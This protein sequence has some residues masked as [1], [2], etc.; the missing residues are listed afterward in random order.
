MTGAVGGEDSPANAEAEHR[1]GFRP[2]AGKRVLDLSR[3]LAGPW[4][5]QILAD[6]GADVIKVERPGMGDDSRS[7]GPPFFDTGNASELPVTAMF[8]AANRNKRSITVDLSRKEGQEIIRRL[9][10]DADI[11]VENFKVGDLAKKGLDYDSLSQINPQLI[12]CSITGYGQSGPY[13]SRGGYDPVAQAMSGFMSTTGFPETEPGG[14]PMKAGPSVL[15]MIAGLYAVIAIEGALLEL[16][17]GGTGQHIDISLLDCGIAIMAQHIA[18]YQMTGLAPGLIGTQANGGAPGGAY[19][20]A[21]GHIMIAPGNQLGFERLCLAL[22]HSELAVDKRFDTNSERVANRAELT[23]ILDGI[24]G[25]WKVDDLCAELEIHNVPCS[26]INSVDRALENPQVRHR[27]MIEQATIGQKRAPTVRNPIRFSRSEIGST[28]AIPLPGEH[29][30]EVL[31]EFGFSAE[32]ID[33]L[34][35]AGIF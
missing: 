19:R 3:V 14:G 4:A 23:G 15:D 11:F 25:N 10:A 24:I 16:A 21:D 1:A 34:Q 29:T 6:F 13:R 28:H 8:M 27:K 5:T 9:A 7:F 31:R 30:H 17:S 35:A 2:L 33:R 32:E 26:P 12:Y 20:C 18:H 22:G